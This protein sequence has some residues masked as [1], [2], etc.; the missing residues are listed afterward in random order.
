[1]LFHRVESCLLTATAG[2]VWGAS[3]WQLTISWSDT[4]QALVRHR[5]PALARIRCLLNMLLRGHL[6]SPHL[7]LKSTSL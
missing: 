2:V 6:G 3:V 7:G 1:M 5:G 4:V